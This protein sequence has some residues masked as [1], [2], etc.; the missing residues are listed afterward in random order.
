MYFRLALASAISASS[1]FLSYF[2]IRNTYDLK[3]SPYFI[4][5]LDSASA[6][7]MSLLGTASYLYLCIGFEPGIISCS[8]ILVS[9]SIV[10]VI[11]PILTFLLAFIRHKR[12]TMNSPHGFA[13][14]PVLNLMS[15]I[16]LSLAL[17][18][19][20]VLLIFNALLELK[21]SLPYNFCMNVS[22]PNQLN[23]P[24][25]LIFIFIPILSITI[26]TAYMDVRCFFFIRKHQQSQLNTVHDNIS[27]R[28]SIISTFLVVPY[29]VF[30]TVIRRFVVDFNSETEVFYLLLLHHLIIFIRN[31]LI[32]TM[33]FRTNRL[34]ARV[35]IDNDRERRQELERQA[36]IKAREERKVAKRQDSILSL[37]IVEPEEN[38]HQSGTGNE[39]SGT[40]QMPPIEC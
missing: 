17:L 22:I 5:S 4:L 24:L 32:S 11:Q 15:A 16:I 38:I 1:N 23:F 40:K 10:S 14:E 28:A 6:S 31:P 20:L 34:N 12:I 7:A 9:T 19:N 25:V 36:A 21:L 3:L 2:Y 30:P 27:F 26:F 37:Q 13:P 33:A 35:D 39:K 18:Y 8:L 29:Y